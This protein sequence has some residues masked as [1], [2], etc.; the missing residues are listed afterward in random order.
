MSAEMQ[1]INPSVLVPPGGPPATE[2]NILGDPA[3]RYELVATG[4][5]QSLNNLV[6]DAVSNRY[7]EG[8]LIQLEFFLNPDLDMGDLV[9]RPHRLGDL[10]IV[11]DAL[12]RLD[13]GLRNAGVQ[14]WPF[15]PDVFGRTPLNYTKLDRANHRVLIR[16]I[17]NPGPL[18]AVLLPILINA[19]VGFLIGWAVIT[20]TDALRTLLAQFGATLPDIVVDVLDAL[21]VLI[22]IAGTVSLTKRFGLLPHWYNLFARF[23][24]A[25][26]LFSLMDDK[27]TSWRA[28]RLVRNTITQG[29]QIVVKTKDAVVA[30]GALGEKVLLELPKI[31]RGTAVVAVGVAVVGVAFLLLSGKRRALG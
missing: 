23:L 5:M 14:P 21:L 6:S 31:A 9:V 11:F 12:D 19:A 8:E 1:T 15:D 18:V 2:G 24:G 20:L 10:N 17:Q 29:R 16:F 22:A 28:W 27:D 30:V 3:L 7:Q 4:S 25:G 26:V 13:E